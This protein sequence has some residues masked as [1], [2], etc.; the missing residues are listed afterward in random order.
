MVILTNTFSLNMLNLDMEWNISVKPLT[1]RQVKRMIE[2]AKN[3]K[4]FNSFIRNED[5]ARCLSKILETEI[6][7]NYDTFQLLP[8]QVLIVVL[9]AEERLPAGATEFPVNTELRF[10]KITIS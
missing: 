9:Y 3:R 5:L 6:P 10:V 4:A 8:F 7:C 1:F 2:K